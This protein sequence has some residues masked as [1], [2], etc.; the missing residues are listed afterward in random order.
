MTPPPPQADH[1]SSIATGLTSAAVIGMYQM[2]SQGKGSE[3]EVAKTWRFLPA[4]FHHCY[5]FCMLTGNYWT[6]T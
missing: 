5:G 4:A 6:E 1:L 3:K 2:Q